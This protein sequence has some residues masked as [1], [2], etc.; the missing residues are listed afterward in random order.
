DV[1][2]ASAAVVERPEPEGRDI[3][4][5]EAVGLDLGQPAESLER[6]FDLSDARLDRYRQ[7]GVGLLADD[8]VDVQA[9]PVLEAADRV[10]ELGLVDVG[11]QRLAGEVAKDMEQLAQAGDTVPVLARLHLAADG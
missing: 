7:F 11:D 2:L 3:D 8:A 4:R 10:G 1:R 5:H 6:E 9:M